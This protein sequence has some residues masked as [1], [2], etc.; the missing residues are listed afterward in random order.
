MGHWPR[1]CLPDHRRRGGEGS[2]IMTRP[3]HLAHVDAELRGRAKTAL[4]PVVESAP[5]YSLIDFT[6]YRMRKYR[7]S[8]VHRYVA[9]VLERVERG[10][11]RRVQIRL[12]P[13]HGKTE[14]S[15]RSYPAFCLGR[16]P[17]R[18]FLM[19]SASSSLGRTSAATCATSSGP[20][21]IS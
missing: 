21:P 18:Q 13:R 2:I 7:P 12:P 11:L 4:E 17:S 10:E 9:E 6:R 14:L 3:P 5:R 16:N 8:K 1:G 15:G 19:A 20:K